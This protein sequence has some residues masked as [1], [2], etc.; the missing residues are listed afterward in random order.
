MYLKDY[1]PNVDKKFKK[2][3]FSGISFI[4]NRVKKDNIFLLLEE[5]IMMEM[6]L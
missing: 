2:T 5:I 4:S 3:Y 1:F 6:I